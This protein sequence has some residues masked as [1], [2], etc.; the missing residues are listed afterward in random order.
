M[1]FE[2]GKSYVFV[3]D[4]VVNYRYGLYLP[5]EQNLLRQNI[6]I[7]KCVEHHKVPGD[8]EDELKYDGF[9]FQDQNGKV[10]DNQYP[11]ASY[12]QLDDS[13]NGILHAADRFESEEKYAE[14]YEGC[15]PILAENMLE[16]MRSA[17][18]RPNAF[19]N[20]GGL[21]AKEAYALYEHYLY[22]LHNIE[23]G[24]GFRVTLEPIRRHDGTPIGN[25]LFS[26]VS[27]L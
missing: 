2:V 25:L 10:W 5:W 20:S 19:G 4:V 24:T 23:N 16:N 9:K 17:L 7:C 8:W 22:T 1:R 21:I 11:K 13:N 3:Q 27:Q 15:K 12:G 26:R 18:F 14:H 6:L